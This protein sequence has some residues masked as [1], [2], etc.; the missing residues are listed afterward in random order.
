[1]WSTLVL[2]QYTIGGVDMTYSE[3]YCL[4]QST[5]CLN[6][7]V[8]TTHRFARNYFAV[9]NCL[10]SASHVDLSS[11]LKLMPVYS[12]LDSLRLLMLFYAVPI[13]VYLYV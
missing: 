11:Q 12:T 10:L 7:L 3:G 5:M 4:W 9:H 6:M 2:N 8:E 13:K 1:M